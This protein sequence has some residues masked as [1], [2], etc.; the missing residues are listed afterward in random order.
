MPQVFESASKYPAQVNNAPDLIVIEQSF[1]RDGRACS[2]DSDLR[3]E[4]KNL[5]TD[6]VVQEL[7]FNT[8]PKIERK[9][10]NGGVYYYARLNTQLFEN[11][12]IEVSWYARISGQKWQEYPVKQIHG[13]SD[14][15]EKILL[16]SEVRDWVLRKLGWPKVSVE[17]NESHISEAIGDALILLNRFVPK[18]EYGELNM[19]GGKKEYDLQPP[20]PGRGILD[21]QFRRKEGNPII[22]DPIFGRDYPRYSRIDFDHYVLATTFF[23][24]LL[25]T[26][27]QAQLWRWHPS[28]PKKLFI[29]TGDASRSFYLVSYAFAV[30]RRLEEISPAHQLVFKRTVLSYAKETL[31]E[32]REK[33]GDQVAT[34]NGQVSLNGKTLKA[35]AEKELEQVTEDIRGL[36][37]PIWPQFLA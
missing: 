24:T 9:V 4:I 23:E 7:S 26:T 15:N 25:N 20:A 12:L 21:V 37:L 28:Q 10:T 22:H 13:T 32:I 8:D 1:M 5:N 18:I 14:T 34:A 33:F 19:V 29:D 31:G 30:D 35:E 3:V 36:Q 11:S 27:G 16:S 17:L 6:L 2:V